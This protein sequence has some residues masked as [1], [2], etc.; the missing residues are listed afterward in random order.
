MI[1]TFTKNRNDFEH[2]KSV[3]LLPTQ[4]CRVELVDGA[5]AI[6]SNPCRID[7][8]EMLSAFMKRTGVNLIEARRETRNSQGDGPVTFSVFA[9][10][11]VLTGRGKEFAYAPLY[12][13]P[14]RA[15]LD[16]YSRR[17]VSGF[18]SRRIVGDWYI[19]YDAD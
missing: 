19:A 7:D 4:N 11:T 13:G 16:S 3:F 17:S 18:W 1:E 5:A 15:D 14:L 8:P 2:W 6:A 12:H 9:E 10:G